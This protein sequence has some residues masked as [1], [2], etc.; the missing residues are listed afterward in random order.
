MYLTFFFSTVKN[1][2]L[3]K[4]SV[5]C[6]LQETRTIFTVHMH[7]SLP[8]VLCNSVNFLYI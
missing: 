1:L 6:I 3:V 7:G 2:P 8:T 4:Y 5:N